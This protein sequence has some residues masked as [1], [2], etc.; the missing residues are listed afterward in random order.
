MA[1]ATAAIP[2]IDPKVERAFAQAQTDLRMAESDLQG[3]E[4]KLAEVTAEYNAACRLQVLGKDTNPTKLRERM[5]A[6]EQRI[7]GLRS[8]VSERKAAFDMAAQQRSEANNERHQQAER[9][10]I[11]GVWQ[12]YRE[13]QNVLSEAFAAVRRAQEAERKAANAWSIECRRNPVL[14][15]SV[16]QS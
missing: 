8:V 4:R 9:Q 2:Q 10:R 3:E 7:I 13:A 14:A 6:I 16:S 1:T 11:A 15:S 5:S 12:G